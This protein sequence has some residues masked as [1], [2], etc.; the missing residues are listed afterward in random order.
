MA[1]PPAPEPGAAFDLRAFDLDWLRALADTPQD[2]EFHGEGDVLRHTQ[3]VAEELVGSPA[4]RALEPED[5]SELWLAT[6]LHDVGKHATTRWENGRW[7]APGHARR[8]AIIARRVLWEA[9]VHPFARERICGLVRHHMAPYHLIDSEHAVRRTIEISLE[10]GARR[11]HL[12]TRADAL[13]RIAPDIDAL[14]VNVDLFAELANDLGCLDRAYPFANDHARFTYFTRRD[15]DPA[16]AAHDDT[17]SRVVVLS[18]LPGAGKDHWV[19]AHHNGRPTISLDD[20]RRRRG[21]K[22]SDKVAQGQIIQEARERA[23][24]HL[25]AGE[26]FIWNATNLTAQIRAQTI[27]LLTD[28]NA[29]VTI[30]AVET[31]PDVL[32][33]RN[34]DRRHP[35][36]WAAI[37]RMLDRWEAPS[38]TE[39][40]RL[41]VFSG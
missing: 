9:G 20:L 21:A 25:R 3:L 24:G 30:V 41:E 1:L 10:A 5:R 18:G 23:R 22:R 26:P 6:L 35:V 15:R 29:H 17:R 28:Y 34:R 2:P 32:S 33:A 8:G 13:G 38:A 16:Y 11:Q 4:W 27:S 19:A 40:H 12:L 14:T 37:D 36:P 31:P 39:C 7:T